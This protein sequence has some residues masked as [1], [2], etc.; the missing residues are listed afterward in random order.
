MS[1]GDADNLFRVISDNMTPG[2]RLAYWILFL[3][4]HPISCPSLKHLSALSKELHKRDRLFYYSDFCVFE[5]D[6]A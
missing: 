1:E 4:R 3:P 6:S 5:K 2:G